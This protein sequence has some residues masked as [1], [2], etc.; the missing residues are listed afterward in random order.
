ML[1][2]KWSLQNVFGEIKIAVVSFLPHLL[3]IVSTVYT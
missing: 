1:K 3:S 2:G